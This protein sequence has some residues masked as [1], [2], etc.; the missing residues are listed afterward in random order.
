MTYWS[1]YKNWLCDKAN[2]PFVT[3]QIINFKNVFLESKN[4]KIKN[5]K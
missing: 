3:K 4:K 5:K 1:S 2:F